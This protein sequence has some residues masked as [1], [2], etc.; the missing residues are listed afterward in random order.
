[1][2]DYRNLTEEDIRK[3]KN[4][5]VRIGQEAIGLIE[6][7][8]GCELTIAQLIRQQNTLKEVLDNWEEWQKIKDLSFSDLI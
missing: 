5:I 3:I 4:D 7:G 6:R 2:A 1:M 8:N